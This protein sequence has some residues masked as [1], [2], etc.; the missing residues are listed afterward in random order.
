MHIY[1]ACL[2]SKAAADTRL[3]LPELFRL[4]QT[5]VYSCATVA[6]NVLGKDKIQKRADTGI[7]DFEA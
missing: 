7:N 3:V 2:Y 1:V 5:I 6:V 4:A